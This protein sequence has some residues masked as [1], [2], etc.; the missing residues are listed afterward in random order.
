MLVKKLMEIVCG[1]IAMTLIADANA[2]ERLKILAFPDG[3][4]T[5]L[6]D[7]R[8]GIP[9]SPPSLQDEPTTS[10]GELIWE[11]IRD[12]VDGIGM[13]HV[14]YR[15]RFRPAPGSVP[16]PAGLARDGVPIRGTVLGFHYDPEGRLKTVGGAMYEDVISVGGVAITSITEAHTMAEWALRNH[17]GIT[18]DAIE[19]LPDDIA[20]SL[21]N[22][23]VLELVASPAGPGFDFVWRMVVL[24]ENWE[25]VHLWLHAG[26]GDLVKQWRNVYP[27]RPPGSWSPPVGP[28]CTPDSGIQTGAIA[29]HQHPDHQGDAYSDNFV[30]ATEST[31]LASHYGGAVTHQGHKSATRGLPPITLYSATSTTESQCAIDGRAKRLRLVPVSSFGG[32]QPTYQNLLNVDGDPDLDIAAR[33]AGEALYKVARALDTIEQVQAY[34]ASPGF[35]AV[36]IVVAAPNNWGGAQYKPPEANTDVYVPGD[37]TLMFHRYPPLGG[38]WSGPT[39]SEDDD[40]FYA[41]SPTGPLMKTA[42]LDIVAHELGHAVIDEILEGWN[43]PQDATIGSQMHEGWADILAHMTEWSVEN[44]CPTSGGFECADWTGGEDSRRDNG[45][46]RRVDDQAEDGEGGYSLHAGDCAGENQPCSCDGGDPVLDRCENSTDPYLKA[47]RLPLAFRLSIT[48]G[49][50]PV[51]TRD[52][53]LSGCN[54]IVFS[55]PLEEM[56]HVFY[57]TLTVYGDQILVDPAQDDEETVWNRVVDYAKIAAHDLFWNGSLDPDPPEPI[58]TDGVNQQHAVQDAFKAIGYPG[59]TGWVCTCEPDCGVIE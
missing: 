1:L 41:D 48:G 55:R 37:T 44:E 2:D 56:K 5:G 19:T 17:A 45:V 46:D 26:T 7:A 50:N 9:F 24:D 57:R 18:V 43:R 33:P 49:L 21:Q 39:D 35:N 29:Y 31:T 32:G 25:R 27:A 23:A 54:D 8:S 38:G 53:N 4:G 59:S 14:V 6:V 20:T 51:C 36:N 34:G 22:E 12:V 16:L 28:T 3:T 30:K 52:S 40:D 10:R 13:R 15:Q 42:S 47:L 58:C 11:K